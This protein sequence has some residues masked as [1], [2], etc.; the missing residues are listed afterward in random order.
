MSRGD[1]IF[2]EFLL[3][4]KQ[5]GYLS[6]IDEAVS[7]NYEISSILDGAGTRPIFFRKVK[8]F[9]GSVVGN[10]YSNNDLL[11]SA[12]GVRAEK[13][14]E[15]IASAINAPLESSCVAYDSKNWKINTEP[16][17]RKI[18]ILKHYK[19]DSGPYLTASIV[20]IKS[21]RNQGENISVHRMMVLGK[22]ELAARVVPRHLGQILKEENGEADIAIFLGCDP[23]VFVGASLQT[24]PGICEYD[25]A[26][27][28]M[29]GRLRLMKCEGI[30]VAVPSNAEIVLEG[31][32]SARKMV[33]EGPFV[34]LTRTTDE[35]RMQPRIVLKKMHVRQRPIYHAILP[36][37]EEHKLFMGLPQE[38]KV[39]DSLKRAVSRVRGISFPS[40][41]CR[42]F[43]CVVSIEKGTDGDGKTAIINCFAASHSLKLVVA[44]DSDIDPNDQAAVEWAI[45]TRFQADR[46]LVFIEGARGSTLD[47]S[48]NKKGITSKIGIDATLDVGTARTIFKKAETVRNRTVSN[49]LKN[50]V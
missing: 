48:S 19:G 29:G 46:G 38:L 40:G 32:I 3:K 14:H 2:R 49:V 15:R 9:D 20:A 18:P 8:G 13:L 37:G 41:G 5:R 47:P 31:T 43:H 11:A 7:P 42:Y 6:E 36:G 16:D 24:G 28:L 33:K 22:R 21:K 35:V 25:V 50:I 39:I 17:L 45:A 1:G 44:V 26:N 4:L 23:A 12:L 10:L 34:D 30:D 27:T